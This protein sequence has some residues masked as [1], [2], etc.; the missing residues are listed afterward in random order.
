MS[1]LTDW[2]ICVQYMIT[3]KH[4]EMGDPVEKMIP[5]QDTLSQELEE[6]E[7]ECGVP[8]SAFIEPLKRIINM[9][10]RYNRIV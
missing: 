10:C 9:S 1:V 4:I 3:L 6:L 5:F 2:I 8:Y 7:G